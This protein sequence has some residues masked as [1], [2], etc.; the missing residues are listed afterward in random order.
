MRIKKALERCLRC[1]PN[2]VDL[3]FVMSRVKLPQVQGSSKIRNLQQ[4]V[5]GRW[6]R[7]FYSYNAFNLAVS[8]EWLV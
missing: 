3:N 5:D 1:S 4:K 8:P 2:R 7:S 6:K